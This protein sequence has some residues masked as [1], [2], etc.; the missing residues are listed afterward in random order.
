MSDVCACAVKADAAKNIID[1]PRV[2]IAMNSNGA[3][4]APLAL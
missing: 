1:H 3:W 2:G 4:H